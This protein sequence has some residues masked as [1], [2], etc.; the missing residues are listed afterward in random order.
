MSTSI[1]RDLLIFCFFLDGEQAGSL[2][3][4]HTEAEAA[5]TRAQEHTA[6]QPSRHARQTV[7]RLCTNTFFMSTTT[8]AT[9]LMR[10]TRGQKADDRLDWSQASGWATWPA[11]SRRQVPARLPLLSPTLDEMKRK[12]SVF[13]RPRRRRAKQMS[14]I[15]TG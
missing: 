15:A 10:S 9:L 8:N 6:Q 7:H 5:E 2:R 3:K 13:R 11:R 12:K 1:W 4:Q 14:G